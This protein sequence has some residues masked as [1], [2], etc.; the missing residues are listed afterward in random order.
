MKCFNCGNK[1]KKKESWK[2]QMETADGP[3]TV[4]LCDPCGK[5]FNELSKQISEVL[6]ERPNPV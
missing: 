1:M 4:E 6:D 2:L 5:Q 3:H